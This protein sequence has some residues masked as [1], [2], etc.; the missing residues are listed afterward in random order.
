[1]FLYNKGATS[2][3]NTLDKRWFGGRMVDA[4][5][6]NVEKFIKGEYQ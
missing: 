3:R 6:Y 1:M 2:A 4:Q 5:F